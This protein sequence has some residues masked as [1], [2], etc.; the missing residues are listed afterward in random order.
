MR[1][2][3]ITLAF[4]ALVA[5]LTQA[6]SDAPLPIAPATNVIAQDT[7]NDG[8]NSIDLRWTL[9]A[10]DRAGGGRITGYEILRA[11]SPDGPFDKVGSVGTGEASYTDASVRDG[12]PYYYK[13]A[14]IGP[15]Q[16][17]ESAASEPVKSSPSWFNLQRVNMLIA[18][19]LACGLVLWFIFHAKQGKELFIRRIAGLSAVDEALGRA[20]EMGRPVL[21]LPSGGLAAVSD[22]QTLAGL[23]ILGQVAKKTAE[24]DTP[25]LVPVSDPLVMTLAREIVKTSYTD[26]GR[27]DAFRPENIRYL[28]NEQFAYTAGVDGI[29]LREKP[30]ANF[31]IGTFYAESLILAE[32]GYS[33]GAIQI[34]GTAQISQLPFFVAACDYTLIGEE[35]YA[36]SAYLSREPVLL[37]SLKGQDWGKAIAILAVALGVILE[38]V[39]LKAPALHFFVNLFTSR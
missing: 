17:A 22:I 20:T 12:K 29:M 32:T 13:I 27:P 23:I 21:F 39:A 25:L 36:A 3:L 8:G 11:D 1:K 35:I 14:A 7:P 4:L 37:G 38:T 9:S 28:T 30:A 15:E 6:N 16:G 19:I 18:V 34:A 2:A 33:T 26:A 10:D 5:S 31:M 24:F